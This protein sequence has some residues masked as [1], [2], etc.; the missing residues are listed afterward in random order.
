M[1]NLTGTSLIT[2][3]LAGTLMTAAAAPESFQPQQGDQ[4]LQ[5]QIQDGYRSL[6]QLSAYDGSLISYKR[7]LNGRKALQVGLGLMGEL[8]THDDSED[9]PF[10]DTLN[11]RESSDNSDLSLELSLL[12][13]TSTSGERS[14]FYYGY[15]PI[16]SYHKSTDDHES[17]N[18]HDT[19]QFRIEDRSNW[20]FGAG[21]TGVAGVEW[22]LN[23]FLTLHAEYRSSFMYRIR[24]AKQV[25][26]TEVAEQHHVGIDESSSFGFSSDGVRF[27]LSVYF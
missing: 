2:C 13:V 5:F 21:L 12:L 15:G 3:L 27:G 11:S 9:Y 6:G 20:E 16:L 7:L 8:D 24:E 10:S 17:R 26:T 1:K 25:S 22:A 18:N 4:A 14:W 19:P 23:G